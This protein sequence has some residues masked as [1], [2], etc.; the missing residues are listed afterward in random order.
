MIR[1][2]TIVFW[3]LTLSLGWGSIPAAFSGN[4]TP[5][6]GFGH[7]QASQTL[8]YDLDGNLTSEGIWAFEWDGENRLKRATMGALSG[9][10]GTN[11]FKIDFTYDYLGRRVQKIISTYSS[12]WV[13]QSTKRYV[14]DLGSWTPLAVVDNQ[15]AVQQAYLWGQDLSGTMGGAGGIGGLT[16]I[17]ELSNNT[18]TNFHFAGYDGNG[19]V[20]L[21]VRA[22]DGAVSARYEYSPFGQLIRSTGVMA[23]NNPFRFSTKYWDD[24]TDLVYYGYRYYTPSTGTWLSRDPM[25]EVGFET[26]VNHLERQNNDGNL[27]VFVGNSPLSSYDVLGLMPPNPICTAPYGCINPPE[28]PPH[29]ASCS[30]ECV[31]KYILKIEV[32]AAAVGSGQP[33]LP[34][35]FV[36]PGS[37]EGTSIAGKLTDAVLGD[38]RLPGRMPT[39]TQC[40][41]L[42]YTKSAS[43]LVSRYIP[44]IGWVFLTYDASGLAGCLC[45]CNGI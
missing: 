9:I 29:K 31:Y 20:S 12:G 28:F 19:N 1:W 23:K 15:L 35:R 2:L 14:Y 32:A 41:K 34:K 5:N 22:S 45:G 26:V 39:I 38:A 18:A 37:A 16:G 13:V 11:R 4:A 42:T 3:L 21:L 33:V 43:R 7:P 25:G 40:C 44:V 8:S 30:E 6:G 24:E 10:P 17:A 36:T 27:Y